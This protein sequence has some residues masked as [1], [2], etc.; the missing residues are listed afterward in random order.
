MT[1]KQIIAVLVAIIFLEKG[2]VE[3]SRCLGEVAVHMV[4]KRDYYEIL[5]I[6]KESSESEIK[7]HFEVLLENSIQIKILM[8]PVLRISSRKYKKHM[9]FYQ[10]QKKDKNM[11]PMGTIDPRFPIWSR[12]FPRCQY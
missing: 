9:L 12:R 2:T 10:I 1:G 11:T 3:K 7:K 8:T 6:S 4:D 5:G